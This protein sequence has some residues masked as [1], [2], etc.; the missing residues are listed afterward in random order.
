MSKT[1][2][3]AKRTQPWFQQKSESNYKQTDWVQESAAQISHFGN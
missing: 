2:Q 3:R 1:W